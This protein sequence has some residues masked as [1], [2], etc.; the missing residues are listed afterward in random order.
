MLVHF[1]KASSETF[2][3]IRRSSPVINVLEQEILERPFFTDVDDLWNTECFR[4]SQYMEAFRFCLKH[5]RISRPIVPLNKEI[6]SA[7]DDLPAVVYTTATGREI[8]RYLCTE[9]AF[10]RSNDGVRDL[11]SHRPAPKPTVSP[12]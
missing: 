1:R 4:S 12:A 11:Q 5:A 3:E 6:L 2:P 10:N 7:D 8:V 9:L